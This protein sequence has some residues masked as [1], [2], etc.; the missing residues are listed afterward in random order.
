MTMTRQFTLPGIEPDRAGPAEHRDP[1]RWLILFFL[2]TAFMLTILNTTIVNVG[3]RVLT[4]PRRGLGATQTEIVWAVNAFTLLLGTLL[5]TWSTLGDRYGHRR[6]LLAGLG[7]FGLGALGAAFSASPGMLIG[8]QAVMGVG[9]AAIPASTL[10]IITHVFGPEE[11]PKAI[12]VWAASAGPAMAL[13]P[14]VGGALLDNFPW[15]AIFLVNVPIVL[16][17]LAGVTR[18]APLAR[19]DRRDRLDPVGV[20][21]SIAGIFLVIFGIME[22][23]SLG[24]WARWPVLVPIVAGFAV[25]G[26][27]V[28]HARRR[29]RP[30]LDVRLF[31]DP[32]FSAAASVVALAFVGI[33]GVTLF[34][35]LY[36]QSVRQFSALRTG[37]S[38]LPLAVGL[39]VFSPGAPALARKFGP[40]VVV[41][42]GMATATACFFS[43]TFLTADS[44]LWLP[45]VIFFLQGAGMAH[46]ISPATGIIMARV[47]RENA[48]MG[49]A[50]ANL[51]RD[52]GGALGL[53]ALGSVLAVSYRHHVDGVLAALPGPVRA[54][55]GDSIAATHAIAGRLG[56]AAQRLL[57][58]AD[59]AFLSAMHTTAVVCG[60]LG[61]AGVCIAISGLPGRPAKTK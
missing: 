15:G 31:R 44:P 22:G 54:A 21:L 37:L 47:P 2:V 53:A 20:L 18:Y 24:S 52:V 55:A 19:S 12:G 34:V 10:A 29:D 35:M 42:A 7:V 48:G 40:K 51:A 9:G 57:P 1:R 5:V 56:P 45:M 33:F 8:W 6:M 3:I 23:G 28:W 50:V 14:I 58:A 49:S 16:V 61:F 39:A 59:T 60:V 26:G 17:V 46:V 25:L 32:R 41:S 36:F 11:R 13:G 43:Y 30:A 4:D 27:F 38:V